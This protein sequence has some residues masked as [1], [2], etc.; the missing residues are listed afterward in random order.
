[1]TIESDLGL[2]RVE[3]LEDLRFVCFRVAVDLLAGER[4]TRRVAPGWVSDEPGHVAD[5]KNDGVAQILKVL[6]L[7]EEHGVAQVQIGRRG[8]ESGLHAQ[9]PPGLQ[10]LAEVLFADDF[11]HTFGEVGDLLIDVHLFLL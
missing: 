7:A 10:P 4:R 8:V 1:M 6:H 5:Q 11:G 2:R 3:N 9:R